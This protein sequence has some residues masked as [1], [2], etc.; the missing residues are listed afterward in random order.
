ML[1]VSRGNGP[2]AVEAVAWQSGGQFYRL[3]AFNTNHDNA[4]LEEKTIVSFER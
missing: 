4:M 3:D 1:T 2:H